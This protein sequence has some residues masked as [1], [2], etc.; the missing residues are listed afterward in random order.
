M[1]IKVPPYPNFK[2]T[3]DAFNG[4][5]EQ[6]VKKTNSEG[7]SNHL[8]MIAPFKTGEKR[9]IHI[10]PVKY[11]G[12]T[13]ITAFPNPIHLFLSLSSEHYNISEKVKSE[14][15]VKCGKPYGKDLYLLDIE[16][17]GT[18]E[19][20]NN[21]IKYRTSSIIMLVSAL[22]AFLN[23]IIPNDFIYKTVKKNKTF[24]FTKNDIESPKI[25]FREKMD[26]ILPQCSEG[27]ID[28][29]ILNNEHKIIFDLYNS[30]KDLIHL[31][32]NSQTDFDMYFEAIDRMLNL[33]ILL[34]I[35]SVIEIMNISKNEFIEI[36]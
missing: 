32:T 16:E 19:Y 17:N 14:N 23:H 3:E 24:E 28:W 5:S 8:V 10:R 18:H 2:I 25:S 30:R 31:K 35:E 36:E 15:F 9:V 34:A 33:D 13:Y 21:Y 6:T 27:K 20:Y 1:K 29:E 11:N 26:K 12:N 7:L 4:V 22:E